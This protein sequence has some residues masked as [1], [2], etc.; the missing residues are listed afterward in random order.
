MPWPATRQ[1]TAAANAVRLPLCWLRAAD[2]ALTTPCTAFARAGT[3]APVEAE[4]RLTFIHR[5]VV[6]FGS[7]IGLVKTMQV[8]P[9]Q[10]TVGDETATAVTPTAHEARRGL[11]FWGGRTRSA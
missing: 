5:A 8:R 2:H 11:G 3:G 1:P 6:A 4:A 10:D 7:M 9:A